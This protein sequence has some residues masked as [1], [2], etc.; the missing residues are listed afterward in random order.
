MNTPT[1]QATTEPV[2]TR[3]EAEIELERGLLIRK[4]ITDGGLDA[5]MADQLIRDRVPLDKAREQILNALADRTS[6]V[7]IRSAAAIYP[8][9]PHGGELS[10]MTEALCV[11][12]GILPKPTVSAEPYLHMRLSDMAGICLESAGHRMHGQAPDRILRAA[13]H[14]TSD[15]P[16][17]LLGTGERALRMGYEAFSG[18]L[19]RIAKQ[20]TARDFR[21]KNKLQLSEAPELLEVS[22]HGEVI[23]GSMTESKESYALATY[24]RIF[25]LTR[26]SLVND[27][28]GAFIDTIGKFGQSAAELVAKKLVTLL[29]SNPVMSDGVALFHATH[30]NLAATGGA[31]DLTSLGAARK[32]MRL[33]KGLD[34]V[35]PINAMPK[36]LVVPAALETVA[37]QYLTQIAATQSADVNPFGGRLELVV[38]PRLDAVSATAWYLAA[39]SGLIDG[40][41]FAYLDGSDG[42]I[43][44]TK[45]GWEIDGLEF[46][47][48]L[49]FGC[50]VLDHR[51]LYR[52]PG[53]A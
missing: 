41:E 53:P 4:H 2:Q 30:G 18:G 42:P 40:L 52:N 31:I 5:K 17:L 45:E 32:A 36:F 22:E 51:G 11:R 1:K 14:T 10:G 34:G 48:T 37:E 26:Q 9:T 35:T 8:A 33:Q 3:S 24:A 27:D 39:D 6:E 21:A 16:N 50:G 7:N 44:E 43:F 12:A 19:I 23:H 20:S 29:Q 15:F 25:G 38:D 49:D 13:L 47:A 46:K 28:L